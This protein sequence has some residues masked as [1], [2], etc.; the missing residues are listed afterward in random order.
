MAISIP[1]I[2]SYSKTLLYEAGCSVEWTW[3]LYE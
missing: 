2:F 1:F 3:N